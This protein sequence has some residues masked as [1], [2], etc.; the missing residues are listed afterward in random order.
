[1][2]EQRYRETLAGYLQ[3]RMEY[4]V[5]IDL[6]KGCFRLPDNPCKYRFAEVIGGYAAAALTG[7]EAQVLRTVHKP[8]LVR[9]RTLKGMAGSDLLAVYLFCQSGV[10][11]LEFDRPE[12]RSDIHRLFGIGLND[13]VDAMIDS[14]FFHFPQKSERY[15]LWFRFREAYDAVLAR[16]RN[17]V[18]RR[19]PAAEGA[20]WEVEFLAEPELPM[21][22]AAQELRAMHEAM[23]WDAYESY[24]KPLMQMF[25]S[26]TGSLALS[27]ELFQDTFVRAFRK[28]DGFDGRSSISTWL[29]RIAVNIGKDYNRNLKRTDFGLLS[30]A[31]EDRIC[32]GDQNPLQIA[33]SREGIELVQRCMGSLTEEHQ[34]MLDLRLAGLAYDEIAR[35]VGIPRGTVMSRLHHARKNL[36]AALAEEGLCL[37]GILEDL[38]VENGS[39]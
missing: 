23:L 24:K 28:I 35:A 15:G 3:A 32:D 27:E 37:D 26:F 38:I 8:P 39:E 31:Q 16:P 7:L 20:E 19:G 29:Y 17:T 33:L 2:G 13:D 11:L 25:F 4:E 12:M 6:S 36:R 9:V 14:G 34:E 18:M 5:R 1:M 10:N 30:E 21:D 22:A